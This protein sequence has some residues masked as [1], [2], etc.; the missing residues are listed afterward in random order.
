MLA[1][2]LLIANFAEQHSLLSWSAWPV[3]LAELATPALLAMASTPAILG[4]GIDISVAP[5]FTFASVVI[6]VMLLGH[7][8]TSAFIVVPVAVGVGAVIGLIN[9]ALV[10]Y[11]RYQAVVATLCMN[12]ILSGFALGYAPAPV[13][14]TT[15]WLTAL[16]GTVGGVPGGLILLAV[17]LLAWWGLS[18]TPFVRTLLAVGGS[19]TTAYT[20]GVNVAAVRTLAYTIGGAIAGLAGIAIV[21]QLHQAEAD[22]GFVTPFILMA[23]AAAAIGGNSL[24]GG[25]GGLLGA[26][27]GAAVIFLIENLLGAL[28]LSSFWSQA[29]YGATLII[30]VVFAAFS[31]A[32]ARR[33]TANRTTE[34]R[35]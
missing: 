22:A 10:N 3:T 1:I 11:G 27:L 15:G 2:A 16:G 32:A 12:F 6:E 8:V 35:A 24:A 25:R 20:A 21:A 5:L 7:G 28:G 17:P 30:A 9:G 19:E 4:G 23:I 34:A 29:V 33:A 26:L 14:G 18:R 13:S 31:A